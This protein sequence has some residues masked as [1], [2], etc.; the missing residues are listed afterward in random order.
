MYFFAGIM[1][2]LKGEGLNMIIYGTLNYNRN[3]I[4]SRSQA[5]CILW[6]FSTKKSTSYIVDFLPSFPSDSLD[7]RCFTGIASISPHKYKSCAFLFSRSWNW[8]QIVFLSSS[9]IPSKHFFLHLQ[10]KIR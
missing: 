10:I 5:T 1:R 8:V 7:L 2:R 3:F 6:N 4:Y 9:L